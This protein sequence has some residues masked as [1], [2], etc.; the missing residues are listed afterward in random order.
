[1]RTRSAVLLAALLVALLA[2]AAGLYAYDR[3]NAGSIAKGVRVAGVPVGGLTPAQA[4]RRVRAALLAPLRRPVRVR[5]RARRFQLTPRQAAIGVD[6]RGSVARALARSRRGNL[7]TRAWR[8][9]RG[10]PV[11]ADVP[12]RI[13][14][15]RPAVRR[16]VARVRRAIERPAVDASLDLH[17]GTVAPRPSSN[18]LRVRAR[19]LERAVE[20]R[21]LDPGRRRAVRV[22][23]VVLHPRVTSAQLAARY[24]AII[25]I[26]RAAFRLTLYRHLQLV[27]SYPIAVGRVGLE[28]PAGLYAI[29]DKEINPAWHVPNSSWAG[30]LAG[31]TIPPGDPAN[32]IK[33][34]WLGIYAGAGI[35]GTSEDSSIGTAAS[36]GCIRMHIPDVEELYPL[37]PLGSPV[38]IS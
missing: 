25:V 13:S 20:R 19:A 12:A 7:F 10:E 5:Y 11:D 36:H 29:Q 30:S 2:G 28:T 38:Y 8:D 23:T 26:N 16:L 4:R 15:S 3:G 31:K 37:V 14:W 33:A 34:R 17:T 24:P 32:P 1:M 9:L 6:V 21:L 22:R 18:G 35:H 27:K